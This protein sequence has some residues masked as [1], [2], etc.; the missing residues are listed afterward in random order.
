M[1]GFIGN[2]AQADLVVAIEEWLEARLIRTL[3][4]VIVIF[5]DRDRK[6]RS[7]VELIVIEATGGYERGVVAA[8]GGAGLPVVVVNPRQ[9]RDFAKS[10]GQLAKTDRLDAHVLAEGIKP[11]LRR[12]TREEQPRSSETF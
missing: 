11:E 9:V 7:T 10:T 5:F 6:T 1:S 2:V 12:Q 8:L 4:V 3:I